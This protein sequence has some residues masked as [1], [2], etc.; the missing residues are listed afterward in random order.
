M[1]EPVA[2]Q[3]PMIDLD[4]FER[5]LRR[6]AAA[7]PQRNEDPLAELARL[8]DGEQD[9]YQSVFQEKSQERSQEKFQADFQDTFHDTFQDAP[10]DAR[11]TRSQDG[12]HDIRAARGGATET[13]GLS[14]APAPAA[15][16]RGLQATR[17]TLPRTQ[18]PGVGWPASAPVREPMRDSGLR[19]S[20]AQA[21]GGNFAAIEAGLRGS[22]QPDY[23]TASAENYAR[24]YQQHYQEPAIEEDDEH[25]LDEAQVAAPGP[26]AVAMPEPP[27]SRRLLYVTAAIILVG[28]GGIGATFAIK[29]SPQSPQQIAMIKAATSP[30]KVQAPAPVQADGATAAMQDGSVLDKTPQPPPVGI[31]NRAE[32]PV[33]LGQAAGGPAKGSD[34]DAADSVPVPTPPPPQGGGPTAQATPAQPW[35]GVSSG[36][37]VADATPSGAFGPGGMIQA[38]K[39]KTVTVRP[40]GTFASD[41]PPLQM[42]PTA[43][44][45]PPADPGQD[46]TGSVPEAA[47][48]EATPRVVTTPKTGIVDEGAGAASGPA[49]AAS[50]GA[51]RRAKAAAA[52]AKPVKVADL[53]TGA[54]AETAGARAGG[55]FAVQ[56]GAGAT[57]A[58]AYHALTRLAREYGSELAG[59]ELK[60]HHAKVG[61]KT[62][63]RVRVGGLSKE[64]AIKL[65]QSLQAK[66]GK[67][68]V[69][70][71]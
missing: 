35:Q 28:I 68:F 56:L 70:R 31:I 34:V 71:D 30:A 11:Q 24:N 60:F 36:A 43:E 14:G 47:T 25:W 27:R 69:A 18:N 57:E 44:S 42:P 41:D 46:T 2:R 9:P 8:I 66:G 63:Y 19:A 45:A 51:P 16:E 54:A 59:R 4:E 48:L 1:S 39:V 50:S 38:K 26:A 10:Q 13:Q 21:L 53:D 3:R 7:P 62:V 12:L 20:R 15:A 37:Q 22:I 67:C 33:D 58:E 23:R 32:E 65:C 5:R 61:E 40:D 49:A 29:R 52:H 64:A 55:D 17:L 6:P